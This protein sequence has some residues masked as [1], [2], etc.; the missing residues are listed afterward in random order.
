MCTEISVF[1]RTNPFQNTEQFYLYD[2]KRLPSPTCDSRKLIKI[3]FASIDEHFRTG[4]EYKKAG[5]KL[6]NLFDSNEYQLDLLSPAESDQ[7]RDLMKVV[8]KIN[9]LE[10]KGTLSFG[11]CGTNQTAWK[12]NRKFKSPKYTTSWSELFKFQ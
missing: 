6:S 10:G 1:A 3:A 9:H 11:A 5:I 7:D 2:R 8:D 4:Y 12:M